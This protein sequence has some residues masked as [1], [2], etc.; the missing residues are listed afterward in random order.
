MQSITFVGH[1]SLGGAR[2]RG[3]DVAER[4]QQRGYDTQFY[5]WDELPSGKLGTVVIVKYWTPQIVELRKRCRLLIGDPLDCFSQTKPN[6]EPADFWRWYYKEVRPDIILSTSP[7]CSETMQDCGARSVLA[8]HH[9]DERIGTDWYDPN[10][11]VVY[12]GG[13]RF[14]GNELERIY[15]ACNSIGKRF[16]ARYD[17]DCWQVL[18]G[19]S[20]SLCVRYGKERTALNLYC[21][22]TVKVANASRAGIPIYATDDPAIYS[23]DSGNRIY[24]KGDGDSSRLLIDPEF[25]ESLS[26]FP[27][28]WT[29]DTHCELLRNLADA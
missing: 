20:L 3:R 14:L 8:P 13:E 29:L 4:L 26:V 18:K 1:K 6:A 17:K 28:P 23:L 22:P 7:A 24:L 12:A 5:A 10:G 19:A 11:P 15:D 25:R 21:K 16:I 9:A 2:M 27:Y